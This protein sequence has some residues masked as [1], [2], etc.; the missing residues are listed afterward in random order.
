MVSKFRILGNNIKC[1]IEDDSL[2]ENKIANICGLSIIDLYKV[3]EG[4]L[5]LTAEQI[6][7]IADALNC[8]IK[9]LFVAPEEFVSYG[10]CFGKF[11]NSEDEEIILNIIDYYISLVEL[12]K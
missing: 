9:Q 10:T 11:T 8:D 2:D 5:V 3:F 1:L 6:R 7:T 12:A 4:R